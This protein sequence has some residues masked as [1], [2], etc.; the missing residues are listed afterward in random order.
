MVRRWK[1]ILILA[2]IPLLSACGGD[3]GGNQAEQLAL[4]IRTEFLNMTACDASMEVTADYGQ[5]VYQYSIEVSY[6]KEGDTVLSVT[7]PENIA[8]ITACL[9]HGQTALEYDGVR[10]ETGPLSE[11]GLSPIDAVPA[12]LEAAREGFLAECILEEMDG[13]QTLH[14]SIRDPEG[15][16]GQG[17]E[18]QL[19]FDAA[20]HTLLRGEIA[21]DGFTVIQ[22]VFTSFSPA[23]ASKEGPASVK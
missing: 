3:G 8:G 13:S 1:F 7:A 20:S 15:V 4:E 14:A 2:L 16:P 23:D 22:C 21:Q 17:Q 10:L 6:E 9:E 19:W 18:I 12:L 11:D 5:R